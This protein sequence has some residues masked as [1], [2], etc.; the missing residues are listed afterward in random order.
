MTIEE[1]LRSADRGAFAATPET[2]ALN[3]AH[4]L[5]EADDNDSIQAGMPA[6]GSK[7]EPMWATHRD[8]GSEGH[9]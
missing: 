5:Q 6:W 4:G 1:F 3:E 2:D 7:F 9:T 8:A